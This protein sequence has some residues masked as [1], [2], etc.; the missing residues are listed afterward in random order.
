MESFETMRDDKQTMERHFQQIAKGP[1]ECTVDIICG[2]K[3]TWHI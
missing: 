1:F 2:S 3:K